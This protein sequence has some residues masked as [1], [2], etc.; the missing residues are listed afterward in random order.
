[1]L[2]RAPAVA[3][4]LVHAGRRGGETVIAV[5]RWAV[6][7]AYTRNFD[8]GSAMST[9]NYNLTTVRSRHLLER[10]GFARPSAAL[11]TPPASHDLTAVVVFS[12]IGL[13]VSLLFALFF[14]DCLSTFLP[15]VP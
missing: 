3:R 8:E 5:T 6:T 13:L 9:T 2:L 12:I 4:N 14:P 1:L 11:S 10:N 7:K 15:Q